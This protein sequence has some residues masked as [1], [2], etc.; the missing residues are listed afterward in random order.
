MRAKP[1][2]PP[3][4]QN[5]S[6]SDPLQ[7]PNGRA[8]IAIFI[9]GY[10]NSYDEAKTAYSDFVRE[11]KEQSLSGPGLPVYQFFWPGDEEM[12]LYSA[13][14][15]PAQL[16]TVE[17]AALLL[18][19]YLSTLRGPSGSPIDVHFVGHSLGNRLLLNLLN[20]PG[21]APSIRVRSVTMMAPA[22]PVHKVEFGGVLYKGCMIPAYT[23]VFHSRADTVLLWAFPPGETACGDGF[24]P[25]AV[26]RLG[27]PAANWRAHYAFD[28]FAH[29]DYWRKPG[30][31]NLVLTA[32]GRSAAPDV[33]RDCSWAHNAGTDYRR[34]NSLS[35][36]D[37]RVCECLRHAANIHLYRL[38][39]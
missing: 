11:M 19:E 3:L 16:S 10:N 38:V 6:L 15:F 5:V 39:T 28:S 34:S 20:L 22:V 30:P 18:N 33:A 14:A 24:F 9:H 4:A 27:A 37:D 23:Q 26:G 17:R 12:K 36:A 1:A 29:G 31:A 2:G 25:T 35:S 8:A 13:L 7:S 32:L 21:L